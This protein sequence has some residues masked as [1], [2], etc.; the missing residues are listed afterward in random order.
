MKKW[1]LDS[2]FHHVVSRVK[3]WSQRVFREV[4]VGMEWQVSWVEGFDRLLGQSSQGEIGR[5]DLVGR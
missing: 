4:I 3:N 2:G 1:K 5:R